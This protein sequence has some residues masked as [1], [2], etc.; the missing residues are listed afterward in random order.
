[1]GGVDE[2]VTVAGLLHAATI[3]SG[4]AIEDLAR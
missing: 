1:M 3:R 4:T 2:Y